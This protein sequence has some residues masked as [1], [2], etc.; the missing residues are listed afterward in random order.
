VVSFEDR[1]IVL[2]GFMGT[3]KST[4]GR[5]L[6]RALDFAWVDTDRM[7][8][9]RHGP[10]D[11]IFSR[12]GETVFRGIERNIVSELSARDRCVFSTG[13]KMLLDP[14]NI[15]SFSTRGRIFCLTAD[16]ETLVTRLMKSPT[17]RP[18]LSGEDPEGTIRRL[19]TERREGY[20]RF[21]HVDSAHQ[22]PDD[23]T[24][25]LVDL[26]TAPTAT[27]TGRKGHAVLG[28]ATSGLRSP[29]VVV[30]DA[31]VAAIHGPCL[32]AVDAETATLDDAAGAG[33]VV[34]LGG[35]S[36]TAA[37][38]ASMKVP[39]VV[40]P[41]TPAAMERSYPAAARVVVDLATLQTY[42]PAAP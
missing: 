34:L 33:S 3:G 22:S 1:N 41:T 7:I 9:T 23:V 40:V 28:D 26:I 8:E 25:H 4:V 6:A 35:A 30:S 10:I 31:T 16:T 2:T 27:P 18:L 20:A 11:E 21:T 24:A 17:P 38:D 14:R 32:G 13:G 39:H 19:L 36:V 42:P 12:A 37:S 29:V 15:R 5:R